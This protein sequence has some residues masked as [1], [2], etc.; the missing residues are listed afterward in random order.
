MWSSNDT[1]ASQ[2]LTRLTDDPAID[3]EPAWSADGNQIYF[4]SDRSGGPQVYRTDVA[5][6]GR[7]QRVTFG[8]SYNARPRLSPDGRT[9]AFVTREGSDY[10]IAVQDLGSVNGG[11]RVLTRG[12]LD[13]SPAFAPNGM[14]ILYAGRANG[15]GTLATVSVD[16]LV[17]QRLK[18]DRGEVREPVWGPFAGNP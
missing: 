4:T 14:S 2:Q 10:R 9:L 6:R 17:T 15:R 7:V 3:T 12:S 5:A 8:S 13:E 11:V 16:G 18:S 1:Y